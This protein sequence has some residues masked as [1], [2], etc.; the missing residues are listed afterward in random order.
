[1]VPCKSRAAD[2]VRAGAS[3]T[4]RRL[5]IGGR[6][7]GVGFRPFVYRLA[8]R[9]GIRGSVCN[10]GCGVVIEGQATAAQLDRFAQTLQSE[11]PAAATLRQIIAE[12]LPPLANL[13][14]FAI[15][16]SATNP[17]ASAEVAAD[18]AVCPDCLAEMRDPA[19]L[20][21]H[22][23]ALTNCTR[24]GP[25]YSI[26]RAIP[27]DRRHTT[28]AGFA[29][30]G[31]CQSEYDDPA[32]RRFH[33]QPTACSHCGPQIRLVDAAGQSLPGDP[34]EQTVLRLGRPDRRH[35]RYRRFSSGRPR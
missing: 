27:Y 30:C 20:R 17:S 7:Q 18:M 19:N 25:R 24:C 5:R 2:T 1:M 21:R 16:P 34:I 29:M 33:A 15:E 14:A 26:L 23:Y 13:V 10:D 11:A 35:Q 6:V 31:T 32:D 8:A 3:P 4:R 9:L 22:G 28:M 12:E